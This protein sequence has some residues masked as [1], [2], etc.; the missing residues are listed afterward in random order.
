MLFALLFCSLFLGLSY[1][2]AQVGAVDAAIGFGT[3]QN[4]GNGAGLDFNDLSSCVPGTSDCSTGSKHLGGMA[5]GF[6]GQVMLTKKYGVGGEVMFQPTHQ[7]YVNFNNLG[8]NEAIKSRMTMYDFNGIVR[9]ISNKNAA[10]QFEGGIGGTSVRFYDEFSSSSTIGN[11]N[12]ALFL[13]SANH[14]QLHAGVAV[15]IWAKN[16]FFVRPQFDIHYV[17]GLSD[18]YKKDLVTQATLWV[19]YSFGRQ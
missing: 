19:G 12:Q 9:P 3:M 8:V 11:S 5:M 4:G 18:Q 15:P 16:G 2:H 14:F 17:P 10:L 7:D 1:A 6:S 13:S